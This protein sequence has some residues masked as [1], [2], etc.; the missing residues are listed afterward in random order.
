MSAHELR[1]AAS[2]EQ[3]D[4]W[5]AIRVPLSTAVALVLCF[6]SLMQP[7]LAAVGLPVSSVLTAA[8]PVLKALGLIAAE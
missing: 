6:V 4:A 7:E 8:R 2:S 1:N 3:H 5:N